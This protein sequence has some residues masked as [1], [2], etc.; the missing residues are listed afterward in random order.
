MSFLIDITNRKDP[1]IMRKYVI[2][3]RA[4]K[5]YIKNYLDDNKEL[6]ELWLKVLNDHIPQEDVDELYIPNKTILNIIN[7]F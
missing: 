3:L 6:Q 5:Q 2:A 1:V 4:Y 7:K